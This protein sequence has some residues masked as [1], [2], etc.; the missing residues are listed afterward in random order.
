[1]KLLFVHQ[2]M[3]GQY[4]EI[5]QWL[6]ATGDHDIAFLTQRRNP[7]RFDG[8]RTVIYKPHHVPG[9]DAYGLSKVWEEAT[10]AGFGAAMAARRL[11]QEEGFK[12]DIIVGH[13]GWGELTFLKQVWPDVPIIGYFE[14]YYNLHGGLVGFDPEET[15]SDHAP[16]LMQARNAVPL[17]NIETVDLGQCPTLWQRDRFPRSFHDR[18]Y[19]CHDGIRTDRLGPNPAASLSLGRL[20]RPL[21]RKDEV[22]TYVARNLEKTR[23]FHILM[24]ALP[25]IL[26]ERPEARVLI[27]GGNDVSY[28]G[29]NERPGGLRREME[30]EVGETLDWSRVH[31]LGQIPYP[32]FQK[33]V[34]LSRCHIYLTMPFVLSWSLMEAMAMQATIVASDVLPVREMITHN[35]TGLLVDFHAPDALARQ[36]I[37]VVS[38]PGAYAHLGPAA[39]AH[40]VTHHDF[41][42]RCLPEHL[43]QINGLLPGAK[44]IAIDG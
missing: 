38:D 9:K 35:E 1:M 44:R 4:R 15:V 24:R 20:D 13:A 19:V 16:F 28:G 6:L 41:L 34:Q 21:T 17:A 22:I 39:R 3:P 29:K 43:A 26:A 30:E 8:L 23:G 25:R 11:A 5:V 36:V 27:I 2:N 18:M 14:Y 42:T 10:G 12:P 32:E 7:P 40:V 31:F 37:D 33:L